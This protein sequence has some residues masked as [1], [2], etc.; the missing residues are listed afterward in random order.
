MSDPG[1][2]EGADGR[3]KTIAIGEIKFHPAFEHLLRFQE[4]LLT[5]L[6]QD[7]LVNGYYESQPV[8]L[9]CWPGQ[10]EPVLIDGHARRRA[11]AAAG[12]T[13]VPFVIKR[14]DNEMAALHHARTLQTR[15]R[16]TTDGALYRLCGAHDRLMER[17]RNSEEAKEL[18][19]SGG[20]FSGRSASAK[21]TAEL[22]GCDYKKVERIRK[23]RKNG[24]PEIQEM[25]RDD[26]MSINKAYTL[27][28]EFEK[29]EDEAKNTRKLAAAQMKAVKSAL[30][31]DNFA[32]LKALGDDVFSLLNS[33]VEQY[34]LALPEKERA[35][36]LE[37]LDPQE[38]GGG[39]KR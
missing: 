14:F 10:E 28:R 15:R 12:I 2:A 13:H 25:V 1:D 27:I 21:R 19:P 35:E 5:G 7:M 26:E 8:V 17:G 4:S 33:V 22:L 9:G 18:P 30:T 23:I 38:S 31:E 20:N 37:P 3:L 11:A 24:W 32:R 16:I 29:G 6:I 36:G 34:L 39:T